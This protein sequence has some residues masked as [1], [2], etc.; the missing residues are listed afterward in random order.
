M[1]RERTGEADRGRAAP[2]GREGAAGRGTGEAEPEEARE[3]E[4]SGVRERL[5]AWYRR[6]RS[7][8]SPAAEEVPPEILEDLYEYPRKRKGLAYGLWLVFGLFGAHRIYLDRIWTGVTMLLTGGGL[9]FWWLVDGFLVGGMVD[10]HNALQRSRER[11]GLPPVSLDFMPDADVDALE[12]RPAWDR[13]GGRSSLADALAFPGDA[14]VVLFAGFALGAVSGSTGN[15]EGFAAVAAL[16]VVLN[17][18]SRLAPLH[19][20]PLVGDLLRWSYRVRLFY[21]YNRPG[22]FFSRLTRP[23]TGFLAAPFRK[24]YRNESKLYLTL[25]GA[26]VV[27][28]LFEDVAT[29]VVG[30][31]VARADFG[32]LTGGWWLEDVL[33][34][35]LSIAAFAAPIGA[36]LNLYLLTR[37][38][39]LT[40]W[41]LSG[42]TAAAVLAGFLAVA[43]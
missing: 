42:L 16:L 15:V 23:V 4:E 10:D 33:L 7:P 40:V 32:G 35:L 36:T 41:T 30:P 8:S 2:V 27:L 3:A 5:S 43:L 34:T 31:M 28:F 18:G 29:E 25:G 9:G 26:F 21:H 17:F 11:L 38:P 19:E 13:S 37:R 12:E 6:A 24:K 14:L 22:G 39:H 1:D 20:L